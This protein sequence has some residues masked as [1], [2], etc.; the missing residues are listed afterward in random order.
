MIRSRS[1]HLIMTEPAK[2]SNAKES[3]PNAVIDNAP[4]PRTK[5]YLDITI[6][7]EKTGRIAIELFDDVVPKTAENYKELCSGEK[8][9][10]FKG[11]LFHRV[12][13]QFMIQGGD[14]TNG[15]GTGGKSIYGEKFEDENFILKHDRPFLLSMANSGPGTNGSQFFITTVPTPHLD[16]K[17][18]VFGHVIAGKSVVRAIENEKTDDGDKPL[19]DCVI[20]ECGILKEGDP[21]SFPDALGDDYEAVLSDEPRIDKSNPETVFTAAEA[22]KAFGTKAYKSSNYKLA[23]KKYVKAAKYLDDF[24][25]DDM[26]DEDVNR[27]WTLKA[28]CYSN[29]A[30]AAIVGNKP[31]QGMKYANSALECEGIESSIKAKAYYRRATSHLLGH[32]EE[33]AIKDFQEAHK[34]QPNDVGAKKALAK[35]EQAL[36]DRKAKERKAFSKLFG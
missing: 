31:I 24:Q 17:H 26:S 18:V 36:K 25:P 19:N 2:E 22:I 10:G 34:L 12:I 6:G 33:D 8:G 13:K 14:F 4:G 5:V 21:L 11:S 29:A 15:N 30:Q 9:F 16:G 28:L 7:D 35:A 27:Y 23:V 32:N 1:N 20:S 3:N